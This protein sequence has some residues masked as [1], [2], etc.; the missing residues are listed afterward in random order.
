[1]EKITI[2]RSPTPFDPYQLP[3]SAP[4]MALTIHFYIQ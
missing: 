1:M 3:F 4:H 2:G